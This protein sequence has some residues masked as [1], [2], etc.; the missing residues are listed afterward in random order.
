MHSGLSYSPGNGL[1]SL[2]CFRS[3]AG[4]NLVIGRYKRYPTRTYYVLEAV[5]LLVGILVIV[6]LTFVVRI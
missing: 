5:K 4:M 6:R 3:D 2:H 1:E